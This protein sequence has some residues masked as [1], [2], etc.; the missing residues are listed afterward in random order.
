MDE[1]INVPSTSEVQ[2]H[3]PHDVPGRGSVN[4]GKITGS[5]SQRVCHGTASLFSFLKK[6]QLGITIAYHSQS[7]SACLDLAIRHRRADG[8]KVN[9]ISKLG[10]LEILAKFCYWNDFSFMPIIV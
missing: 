7:A 1:A 3:R 5:S 2:R 6:I 9:Y 10:N 8:H 4:I